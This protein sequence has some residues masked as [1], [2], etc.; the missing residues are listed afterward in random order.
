MARFNANTYDPRVDSSDGAVLKDVDPAG[1]VI[2]VQ[3][4]GACAC[5]CMAQASKG[6]QFKQGHD[7]RLKGILIRAHLTDTPVAIVKHKESGSGFV[8]GSIDPAMKVAQRYTWTKMLKVSEQAFKNRTAR[9]A[10]KA[11]GNGTAVKVGDKRQIKVG[12]WMKDGVITRVHGDTIEV[13]Y[14]TKSGKS[15]KTVAA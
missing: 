8:L 10:R 12:R 5:G 7:A 3:D 2:L 13:E 15:T 9:K 4:V 11:N 1:H 6:R 14:D